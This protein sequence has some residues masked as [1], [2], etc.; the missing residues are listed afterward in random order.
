MCHLELLPQTDLKIN[1]LM[2]LNHFELKLLFTLLALTFIFR[3]LLL[4]QN[5]FVWRE[6]K[7]LEPSFLLFFLFTGPLPQQDNII[8]QYLLDITHLP[9]SQDRRFKDILLLLAE[10]ELL[11]HLIRGQ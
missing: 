7:A 10:K 3:V 4:F 1:L 2:I 6:V 11:H 9:H 8:L 5:T